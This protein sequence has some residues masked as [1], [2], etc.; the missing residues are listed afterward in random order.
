MNAM[1]EKNLSKLRKHHP[2]LYSS[3]FPDETFPDSYTSTGLRE[4]GQT[5]AVA[6]RLREGMDFAYFIGVGYDDTLFNVSA[7]ITNKNRGI[8]IIEPDIQSFF[9]LLNQCDI[10]PLFM[11][12]KIFWAVGDGWQKQL[13]SIWKKTHC[14]AA[15]QPA[16]FHLTPAVKNQSIERYIRREMQSEKQRLQQGIEQLPDTLQHIPKSPLRIWCYE[17]LRGKQKY[18]T[19]QHALLRTLFHYWNELGCETEY[20]T[21]VDG[22]YYPPYYRIIKLAEFKPNIIFLCNKSPVY[23]F[24]LGRELSRSLPI[25]KFIWH[26]DDPIYAEHLLERYRITEDESHWAADYGWQNTLKRYGAKNVRYLPGAVTNIRR[27]KRRGKHKC[28]IVFVGQVRD[29]SAFF[30]RLSPAWKAYVERV[31][32]EKLR[33]PRKDVYEVLHQFPKPEEIAM[34]LFDEL[35]QKILWEANTRFRVQVIQSLAQY[36]LRIYGNEAWLKWLPDAVAKR[37]YKGV[38]HYKHLFEVYRNAAITLNIHSL[39][40]YTCMNVRDFDVPASGG[41]L[42]SDWL[43]RA[44]EIFQP[45]FA[46][47]LPLEESKQPDVFFYRSFVELQKIVD[48]F[49]VHKEERDQCVERARNRVLSRHTYKERAAVLMNAMRERVDNINETCHSFT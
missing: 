46:T 34:D 11:N 33:F 27:G 42:V 30:A 22:E 37:C 41:F 19:I 3:L 28:D 4:T 14:Y 48:Y 25:P 43:P 45:G 20:T 38:L 31:I 40:T 15:A 49:L 13:E 44:E 17:D 18:S 26:A 6:T 23:E 10:H 5:E 29:Q 9:T 8:F 2:A 12:Q 16:F 35:K 24:A 32:A 36:D 21:M 39:Q 47:D 1:A 7:D